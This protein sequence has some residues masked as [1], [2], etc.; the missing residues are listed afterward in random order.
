MHLL[1][2][3]G[4]VE[5][6]P[7]P[8]TDLY[9]C[10]RP[11]F[12]IWIRLKSMRIPNNASLS[13]QPPPFPL[14]IF[15]TL[16]WLTSP[17]P[18][19]REGVNAVTPACPQS[20]SRWWVWSRGWHPGVCWPVPCSS[21]PPTRRWSPSLSCSPRPPSDYTTVRCQYI[22]L[23]NSLSPDYAYFKHGDLI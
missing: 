9:I 1:R 14:R 12:R 2:L 21:W 3:Q 18:L 20:G 16:T 23:S 4:L 10:T 5:P 8:R 15:S 11:V 13:Y 7:D 22:W 6:V 17:L 19:L